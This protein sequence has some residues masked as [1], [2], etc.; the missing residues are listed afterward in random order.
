MKKREFINLVIDQVEAS[1]EAIVELQK[2]AAEAKAKPAFSDE[3]L[4]QTAAK[5]VA[6]KLLSKEASDS[7]MQSFREDP[8]QALLSLQRVAENTTKH[9]SAPQSLGA[10]VRIKKVASTTDTPSKPESDQAWESGF[11]N[12]ANS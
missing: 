2:E 1:Q 8:E 5:L 10:P 6:S 11:G 3:I 7:L 12:E 9:D 4:E